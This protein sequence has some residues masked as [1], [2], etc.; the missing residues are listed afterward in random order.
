MR[1]MTKRQIVRNAC[2]LYGVDEDNIFIVHYVR[3]YLMKLDGV[4]YPPSADTF[5]RYTASARKAVKGARLCGR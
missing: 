2:G 1:F 4:R 5:E 3:M